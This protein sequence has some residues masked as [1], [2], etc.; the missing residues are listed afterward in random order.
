MLA[1]VHRDHRPGDKI[2]LRQEDHRLRDLIGMAGT[3][4][5]ELLAHVLPEFAIRIDAGRGQD[6]AGRY[7]VDTHLRPNS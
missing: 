4:Q 7:G 1:A 3:F 6:R 5:R 2:V